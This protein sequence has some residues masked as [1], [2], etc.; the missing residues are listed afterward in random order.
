MGGHQADNKTSLSEWKRCQNAQ[1]KPSKCTKLLHPCSQSNKISFE[2]LSGRGRKQQVLYRNLSHPPMTH[3]VVKK[4][5]IAFCNTCF[6]VSIFFCFLIIL[7]GIVITVTNIYNRFSIVNNIFKYVI[8]CISLSYSVD[9]IVFFLFSKKGRF[10]RKRELP[11]FFSFL[12]WLVTFINQVRT[13]WHMPCKLGK[14]TLYTRIQDRLRY[15][16]DNHPG[17]W[18]PGKFSIPVAYKGKSFW[19]NLLQIHLNRC[20]WSYFTLPPNMTIIDIPCGDRTSY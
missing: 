18:N 6:L 9:V 13:A 1:Q 20:K 8:W 14:A 17:D 10:G 3:E 4:N 12:T 11:V 5:S 2:S 15:A 19:D 16:L 7:Q